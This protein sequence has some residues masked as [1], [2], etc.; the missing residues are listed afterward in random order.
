MILLVTGLIY[1]TSSDSLA[2]RRL[3]E[4]DS[5]SKP[6]V[7]PTTQPNNS[8]NKKPVDSIKKPK[9]SISNT[10]LWKRYLDDAKR[11]IT[12]EKYDEAE[13]LLLN[14]AKEAEKITDQNQPLLTCLTEQ[15]DLYRSQ[16]KYSEAKLSGQHLLSVLE[17]IHASNSETINTRK[18]L[19][20]LHVLDADEK[21]KQVSY[22]EAIDN[23]KK[24]AELDPTN[25]VQYKDRIA[26]VYIDWGNSKIRSGN[27]NEAITDFTFSIEID[28]KNP[29]FYLQRGD[30]KVSKSDYEGAIIDYQNAGQLDIKNI[31]TYNAK[32]AELYNRRGFEKYTKKDFDGAIADYTKA[33]EIDPKNIKAYSNRA[34]VKEAKKDYDG[35]ITDYSQA[36]KLDS[37]SIKIYQNR[38]V[39]LYNQQANSKLEKGDFTS[40]LA[41]FDSMIKID[42]QNHLIYQNR[43]TIKANKGDMEGAL[44]DYSSAIAINDKFTPAYINRATIH[45]Q[46]GHIAE[47]KKD[48]E[49]AKELDPKIEIPTAI[50]N[51]NNIPV[52][53]PASTLTSAS[54]LIAI[55]GLNKAVGGD[56][57]SAIS[58]YNQAIQK[59]P[60]NATFYRLRGFARE[61]IE[62]YYNAVLDYNSAGKLSS[63][64]SDSEKEFTNILTKA[65]EADP[66]NSYAYTYR[67]FININIDI[68]RFKN[69]NKDN[70]NINSVNDFTKAIEY[71]PK[72]FTAY[73]YRGLCRI[74][75]NKDFDGQ[76]DLIQAKKLARD[77]SWISFWTIARFAGEGDTGGD[78]IT[79]YELESIAQRNP[80]FA[81]LI[82]QVEFEPI[83]R[84][85][86][87]PN[88]FVKN[89]K[90]R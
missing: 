18:R 88:N 23:L 27:Y 69:I 67:G 79:N 32:I 55:E 83:A 65:I 6:D 12:A 1:G 47:A 70:Q 59:A 42:P 58:Y 38:I 45:S 52:R 3:P 22:Q 80:K 85:I 53:K 41:Y 48:Y 34:N 68:L 8:I 49:K 44:A 24:A 9:P 73:L 64:E 54:M 89:R 33:I 14:A 81:R 87:G 17:N 26:M 16:K 36:M 61:Y 7:A 40:A 63:I 39:M 43:G 5:A 72:N 11:S 90:R 74:L 75:G 66:K 10:P 51:A 20:E 21:I 86:F 84:G 13:Q 15:I 25:S 78:S 19:A 30:A 31:T 77:S 60:N 57:N 35:A 82:D 4:P 2:Q 76:K 62:D 28:P 50:A 29:S 37:A 46:M 71:N 56:F